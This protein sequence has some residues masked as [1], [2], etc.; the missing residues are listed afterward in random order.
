MLPVPRQLLAPHSDFTLPFLQ[1]TPST[2]LLLRLCLC[3]F[4]SL[5]RPLSQA[6]EAFSLV[7]KIPVRMPRPSSECLGSTPG[8]SSDS[9]FLLTQ[10]LGGSSAGSSSWLLGTHRGDL[11]GVPGCPPWPHRPCRYLESEPADK[12]A[13]SQHLYKSI[14]QMLS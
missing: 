1:Q 10:P 11:D 13:A 14:N 7:V 12:H 4:H 9:S 3:C 5:K 6:G 8:C 2:A